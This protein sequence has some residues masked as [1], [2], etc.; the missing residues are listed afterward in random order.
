MISSL[1]RT[2]ERYSKYI[3]A[4]MFAFVPRFIITYSSPYF[5]DIAALSK[6]FIEP[7]PPTMT[8]SFLP[9]VLA[10]MTRSILLLPSVTE[11]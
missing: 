3:V 9:V 7:E 10:Q 2:E 4:D 5:S 6:P 8:I 1:S 11:A